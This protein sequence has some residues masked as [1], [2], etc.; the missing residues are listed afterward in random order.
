MGAGCLHCRRRPGC[1]CCKPP[2]SCTK[3]CISQKG[4]KSTRNVE[5]KVEL[6]RWTFCHKS[7]CVT[8]QLREKHA[9]TRVR[10]FTIIDY[11]TIN[12]DWIRLD[13][14]P[15]PFIRLNR[16][17][18]MPGR[19]SRAPRA[20]ATTSLSTK[21]S[22]QTLKSAHKSQEHRTSSSDADLPDEGGSTSLRKHITAIFVDAQK[23]T[24]GH[25]KLVIN[26]RKIQEACCYEPSSKKKGKQEEDFEE[27]D[28]NNEII[29]CVLRILGIKKSET[30]GDRI[31]RFLGVFL[32]VASEKGTRER[33]NARDG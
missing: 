19:V 15:R 14:E 7:D 32:R 23:S 21:S 9:K 30:V 26:L 17:V 4:N 10:L 1:G 25:R 24:T 13:S 33:Y 12:K 31:V 3:H 28:F 27:D 2:H 16:V 18:K 5:S 29:R 22:A 11:S 8:L 20:S 6:V